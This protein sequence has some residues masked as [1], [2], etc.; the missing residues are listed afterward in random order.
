[1]G[2]LEALIGNDLLGPIDQQ[3]EAGV[4][5]DV[6]TTQTVET[7]SAIVEAYSS[8]TL[9]DRETEDLDGVE[10]LDGD[11][12]CEVD[13]TRVDKDVSIWIDGPPEGGYGW[14]SG[15]TI[16]FP[17]PASGLLVAAELTRVSEDFSASGRGTFTRVR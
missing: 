16:T 4:S 13:E 6:V 11:L 3:L 10:S 12:G 14:A 9:S 7:L 5:L 17:T 15:D 8:S 1:M 2:R